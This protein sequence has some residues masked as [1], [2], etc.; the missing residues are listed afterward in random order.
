MVIHWSGGRVQLISY[1]FMLPH[2]MS[3]SF[4]AHLRSKISKYLFLFLKHRRIRSV[5]APLP[6]GLCK[7]MSSVS[8]PESLTTRLIQTQVSLELTAGQTATFPMSWSCVSLTA[9]SLAPL[10][11]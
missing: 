5:A 2:E 8:I 9:V 4:I 1:Q 11:Q 10:R 3:G 7:N 6:L